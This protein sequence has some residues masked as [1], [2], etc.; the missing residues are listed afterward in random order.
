MIW[1]LPS[2]T[3]TP[4]APRASTRYLPPPPR[5]SRTGGPPGSGPVLT[6]EPP[7]GSNQDKGSERVSLLPVISGGLSCPAARGRRC[8]ACCG[9][10][11][12]R[13]ARPARPPCTSPPA[14][15]HHPPGSAAS[16]PL[17]PDQD[18]RQPPPWPA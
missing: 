16:A 18:H 1:V 7:Y 13:L 5:S 8:P 4:I 14:P 2:P 10:R 11:S 15:P 17:P 6:S 3:C 12:E 9:H